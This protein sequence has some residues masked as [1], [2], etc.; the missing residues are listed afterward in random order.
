MELTR[1][2]AR[3]TLRRPAERRTRTA[4]GIALIVIIAVAVVLD[5]RLL[6]LLFSLLLLA[7]IG[8]VLWMRAACFVLKRAEV[9]VDG[10]RLVRLRAGRT[11]GSVALNIPYSVECLYSGLRTVHVSAK[12]AGTVLPWAVYRVRQGRQS[13]WFST[14]SGNGLRIAQD[15]L[16]VTWPPPGPSWWSL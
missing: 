8:Y 16:H 7:S 6:G 1:E 5:Q 14:E 3:T 15:V 11:S 13:L 4:I 10:D 9:T 12:S 2:V